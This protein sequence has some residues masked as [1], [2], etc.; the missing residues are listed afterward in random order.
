[1]K[2]PQHLQHFPHATL[3]VI[4]D[5]ITAKFFL[6]GGEDIEELD[7]LALPR[8][9]RQEP[10]G[11]FGKISE[12]DDGQRL[13]HFMKQVADQITAYIRDHNVARFHLVMPTEIERLLSE[14]LSTDLE[15][16]RGQTLH[17]AL[18]KEPILK[19]IEKL[20]II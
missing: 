13:K 2:L 4:S 6:A 15:S 14:N 7:A 8:D 19:I 11:P 1:M 10:E 12:M 20:Q 9:K 18:M 5:Q 3:I 16:K 17:A